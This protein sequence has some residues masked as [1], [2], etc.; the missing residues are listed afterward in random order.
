MREILYRSSKQL[1][2]A[3]LLLVGAVS[4]QAQAPGTVVNAQD[5][6]FNGCSAPA[7]WTTNIIVGAAD[8]QFNL[9]GFAGGSLNGSCAAVFDDDAAGNGQT[10]HVELL[11]PAVDITTYG[12]VELEFNYNNEVFGSHTFRVSVWDGS[13]WINVFETSSNTPAGFFGQ[14]LETVDVSNFKNANFQVKYEYIDQGAWSWGVGVDNHAILGSVPY[15][16]DARVINNLSEVTEYTNIPFQQTPTLLSATAEN[17]GTATITDVVITTTVTDGITVLSQSSNPQTLAPGE[18]FTFDYP[19]GFTPPSASLWTTTHEVT[20]A[21]VD[22]DPSNNTNV[23]DQQYDSVLYSRDDFFSTFSY[24]IGAGTEGSI[25]NQFEVNYLSAAEGIQVQLGNPNGGPFGN[26][27]APT[28]GAEYSV[29]IWDFDPSTG[30]PG[31][32]VAESAPQNVTSGAEGQVI[33]V[34]FDVPVVLQ[35]GTYVATIEET[36]ANPNVAIAKADNIFAP[37]ENRIWIRFPGNPNSISGGWSLSTPFPAQFQGTPMVRMLFSTDCLIADAGQDTAV[38]EAQPVLLGGAPTAQLG[39]EPYTYAWA[40]STYLDDSTLANPTANPLSA[41][42]YTLTVTDDAGCVVTKEV[43]LGTFPLDSVALFLPNTDFCI[44]SER[45]TFDYQPYGGVL[46]GPGVVLVDSGSIGPGSGGCLPGNIQTI[47]NGGNGGNVGGMVYF[48]VDNTSGFP[49]NLIDVGMNMSAASTVEIYLT[50]GGHAGNETNPGA[51]QLVGTADGSTGPFSGP[52]PGNG[53]LTPCPVNGTVSIPTGVWGVAL[54]T[55]SASHNYTNGNGANQNFSNADIT[56]DLGSASNTPFGAPFTPRVWNGFLN[57]EVCSGAGGGG[58]PALYVFDPD[59]AGVGTHVITYCITNQFGCESCDTFEV[60]V[61]PLPDVTIDPILPVCLNEGTFLSAATPLGTWFGPGIVDPQT[62]EF[63]GAAAGVGLHTV[64]YELVDVNGCYNIDSLEIEVWDIPTA[65]AGADLST[66]ENEGIVIGGSPTGIPGTDHNGFIDNYSWTPAMDLSSAVDPNP[67]AN[68]G[69]TTTYVVAVQD[70]NGCIDRDTMVLTVFDAPVADAGAAVYSCNGTAVVLGGTPSAMQGTA[71]YTFTWEPVAGLN[72][73]AIANPMAMPSVT[74][75]YTLT[76]TDANGCEAEAT[77]VVNVVNGPVADAGNDVSV[78]SGADVT[79]GATVTG[80]GGTPPYTFNWSPVA[81]LNDAT[82]ANPVFSAMNMNALPVPFTY[83]VTVTDANGCTSTDEVT[84]TV[85]PGVI[86]DAGMDQ[87]ICSG[88]AATLGGGAVA[89]NGV[90]PYTYDWKPNVGLTTP[91][92]AKPTVTPTSSTIYTVTVTDGRGCVGSDEVLV[93]VNPLPLAEAGPDQTICKGTTTDIGGL[94]TA[95]N[96]TAPYVYSWSPYIGLNDDSTANP[97][98]GPAMTTTFTLNVV[99]SKGCKDVDVVTVFVVENP[100]ASAGVDKDICIGESIEIGARPAA[101]NGT[102]PYLYNWTP[103][104][105]LNSDVDEN[106]IASPTVTTEYVLTVYDANNCM[107]VDSV[108]VTVN[109]LPQPTVDNIETDYCIYDDI[110]I[111]DGNPKGGVFEGNGVSG[112]TFIPGLAGVGTHVLKYT[113][114]DVNGCTNSVSYVVNVHPE[115]IIYAGDDQTIYLGESTVM[116]AT[117]QGNY[118]YV[119]TP[120]DYLDNSAVLNPD[121]MEPLMTTTYTLT[122][123][124]IYGCVNSDEVTI[125]VDVNT[126][127]NPPNV[128]S[129]NGD[130]INDTWVIPTLDFFPDNNVKL[131]NRWGQLVHEQQNYGQ[132]NAW[133]GSELPEG[134][135]FYVIS[136]DV[137]GETVHRGAVTIVR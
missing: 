91:S 110:I 17:F 132:G 52:F 96:G 78:C 1:L 67:V 80:N 56:L 125:F 120:G 130:G 51:W 74:T 114:T 59:S 124:D 15:Q 118:T 40:P 134:T 84:V 42:T 57:Y 129:P 11:S 116:T 43:S 46:S 6:D 4:V 27:A 105:S 20:I 131:Y 37:F 70:N 8:W 39:V 135:Y 68:P 2:L 113:Y 69:M 33:N 82:S 115:P 10:N 103:A 28:P 77:V 18:T 19:G 58:S 53:T 22:G 45:D 128:F 126:P 66:C 95:N 81:N 44:D 12:L 47:T 90:P 121:V 16:F 25:G 93:V 104:G 50:P 29:A 75:E 60:T 85:E 23:T 83:T 13:S 41:I 38:C 136:L 7:G 108:V 137:Q 30:A 48:T 54:A 24:G 100:V 101:S 109:S 94:P 9:P 5:E 63:S 32:I 127:L 112:S 117:S 119:W 87:E 61:H 88:D 14:V 79:L 86:V 106:P 36:A 76:V 92:I 3:V 65:D 123:T 34:M 26:G 31:N 35:P 102:A 111:L 55:P 133:D 122:A 107:D 97:I 21:E 72:D 73:P 98:A 71:P 99:D 49:I 64:Y 62:G 89:T